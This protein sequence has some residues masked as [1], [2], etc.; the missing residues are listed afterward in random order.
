MSPRDEHRSPALAE[1]V[2]WLRSDGGAQ[3]LFDMAALQCVLFCFDSRP[4][5]TC[6]RLLHW[7]ASDHSFEKARKTKH[8]RVRRLYDQ[9][10]AISR[11]AAL[12]LSRQPFLHLWH[13]EEILLGCTRRALSVVEFALPF[14]LEMRWCC[15]PMTDRPRV[16]NAAACSLSALNL[17]LTTPGNDPNTGDPHR[18][19]LPAFKTPLHDNCTRPSGGWDYSST[20]SRHAD[21]GAGPLRPC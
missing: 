8:W 5:L 16:D 9:A 19:T 21:E 6:S 2:R 11:A 7:T 17:H 4:L 18:N 15:L 13:R 3:S 1:R 20:R 12:V 10:D 14:P